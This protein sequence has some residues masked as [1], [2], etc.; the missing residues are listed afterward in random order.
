M[1]LEFPLQLAASGGITAA[2][3]MSIGPLVGADEDV[4]LKFSHG[5]GPCSFVPRNP[6]G[7]TKKGPHA[8]AHNPQPED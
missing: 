2:A 5:K 7:G 3:S 8:A 4:L 1:R 6:A